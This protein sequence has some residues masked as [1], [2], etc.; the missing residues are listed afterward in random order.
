M[1]K[2]EITAYMR[3]GAE[4]YFAIDPNQIY[5]IGKMIGRQLIYGKKLIVMGNG[6]SSIDAQHIAAEFVGMF[7]RRRRALPAIALTSN[8]SAVTAIG[9]DF[10]YEDVFDR[11]IEAFARPG[12]VVLAMSTSGNSANVLKAVKTANSMEC[13]TIAMTGK[14]G[15]KLNGVAK[16]II[17]IQSERTPI[18]Q[19]A[20]VIVGHIF[21]KIVEDMV[22]G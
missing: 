17:R 2:D 13:I 3:E 10:G 4:S 9:N 21:S 20:H 22:I 11:Q 18:I 1:K 7:E 19:E 16:Q 12:D 15:G 8:M 5:Q 14:S 6:G